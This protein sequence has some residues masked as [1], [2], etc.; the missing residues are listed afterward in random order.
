MVLLY[1]SL[2]RSR[3]LLQLQYDYLQVVSMRNR[4]Q[5]V[6]VWILAPPEQ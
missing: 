4:L 1:L 5:H 6:R 3:V 2:Y